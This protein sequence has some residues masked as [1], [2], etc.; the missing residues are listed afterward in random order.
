MALISPVLKRNAPVLL[1]LMLLLQV[2]LFSI[3]LTSR[4]LESP[5][6]VLATHLCHPMWLP[7]QLLAALV[8][9][10]EL[11]RSAGGA[12]LTGTAFK[13]PAFSGVLNKYLEAEEPYD[14]SDPGLP[15]VRLELVVGCYFAVGGAIAA[16]FR[17]G[18][19]ALLG[20]LLLLWGLLRPALLPHTYPNPER[21]TPPSMQP[22]VF[23]GLVL[24]VLC[25][26]MDTTPKVVKG[27]S[28]VKVAA[29]SA[30]T[31]KED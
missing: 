30:E 16:L 8:Y 11:A 15:L 9:P 7:P 3:S 23:I 26:P 13:P 4:V 19:M 28:T 17:P 18:R 20:F 21:I 2:P 5:V 22:A 25:L 10:G 6:E 14:S 1:L 31:K 27:P 24:A 29:K 12:L